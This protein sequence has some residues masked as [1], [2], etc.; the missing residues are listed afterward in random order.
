MKIDKKLGKYRQSICNKCEHRRK[1]VNQCKLC[2]CFLFLKTKLLYS[3]CP[4]GKWKSPMNSW[5]G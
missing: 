3:E 4:I 2:G 1:I 5:V